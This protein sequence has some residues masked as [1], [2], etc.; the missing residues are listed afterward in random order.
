VYN[1]HTTYENTVLQEHASIVSSLKDTS[2]VEALI[3]SAGRLFIGLCMKDKAD[4][5]I[6][7]N[8]QK[9]YD[10]E[11]NKNTD[12]E[13]DTIRN[14]NAC[15]RAWLRLINMATTYNLNKYKADGSKAKL[16]V[17]DDITNDGH[18]IVDPCELETVEFSEE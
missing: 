5:F 7:D 12:A 16:A 4:T 9:L 3:E 1:K 14:N 17:L 18:S 6:D 10:A 11:Y 8:Y 15:N 13:N 2:A